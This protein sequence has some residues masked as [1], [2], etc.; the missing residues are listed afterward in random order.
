MCDWY[1]HF[2]GQGNF[3]SVVKGIYSMGGTHVAVAIKTLKTEDIPNQEVS[4]IFIV[5]LVPCSLF[6]LYCSLLFHCSS[7][8]VI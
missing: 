4:T 6:L 7:K 5:A 2:I 8:Y 3:G 1:L